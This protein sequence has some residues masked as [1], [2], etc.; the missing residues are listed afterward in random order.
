MIL[1]NSKIKLTP[2]NS[3][4]KEVVKKHG[5]IWRI[6]AISQIVH[7]LGDKPGYLIC[8]FDNQYVSRWIRQTGDK[9]FDYEPAEG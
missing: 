8:P 6:M 1:M 3:K 2:K 7:L 5:D 9:D 4:A